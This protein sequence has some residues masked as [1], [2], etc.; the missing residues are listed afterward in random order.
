[1][2]HQEA[3]AK[4]RAIAPALA[5]RADE[6]L[7][8]RRLPD[9]SV[10]ELHEA[11]MFRILQPKR[12]GGAELE[13]GTLVEVCTELARG[14]A[15]TGWVFGYLASHH[16]ML[17]MW[18][19]EAQD[20]VWGA[21]AATA[22][23]LIAAS[24]IFPGGRATAVDGGYQLGGRWG[25]CSGVD[26]C[27]WNILG[28]IVAGDPA[29]DAFEYRMFL[30]PKSDYRVIDKWHTAGLV[31]TGSREIEAESVFVPAHRTL[32]VRDTKGG[33]TPGSAINPGPLYRIPVLATFGYVV[34]GV[35]LGIAQAALD[36]F[37]GAN[38]SRLASYSGRRL[39]DFGTVQAKVAEAGALTDAA[40]RMVLGN[41]D[42]LMQQMQAGRN[43]DIALRVRLRRDAA[44][45]ATLCRRA[46]DLLHEASGGA[47]MFLAH[48][49]Q[50]AFAD[51][52]AAT[53]HIALS[54]DAIA[55]T[56]GRVAMGY[57]A[58]NN[59]L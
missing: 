5:S 28:G 13:F 24:L 4:A 1:M 12:V 11:G 48:P 36:V 22:N 21:D 19:R 18:P 53:A 25:F 15:S 20:E 49:M 31:A 29:E 2:N 14:S 59:T 52:H 35:P 27:D 40:K 30:L 32:A 39:A 45:A 41:C 38:R 8:L 46:L 51:M 54:W 26:F 58:D 42:E 50:R 57:S 44:F 55:L 43:P 34:A 17:G 3:L 23:V 56:A 10:Q 9:T 33:A 7:A 37:T 6:A 16:W 47:A